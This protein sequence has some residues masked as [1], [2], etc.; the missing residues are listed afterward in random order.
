MF[1]RDTLPYGNS[2]ARIMT[3]GYDPSP[4][5]DGE[6]KLGWLEVAQRLLEVLI[7]SRAKEDVYYALRFRCSR[8]GWLLNLV[9]YNPGETKTHHIS[10]S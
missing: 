4:P 8:I 9:L 2:G 3:F 1:L 7:A 10:R 5:S 6:S